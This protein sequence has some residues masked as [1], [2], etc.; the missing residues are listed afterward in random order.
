[1]SNKTASAISVFR[2]QFWVSTLAIMI[3]IWSKSVLW[4]KSRKTV[5]SKWP[6]NRK[7]YS[8]KLSKS[9]HPYCHWGYLQW[10]LLGKEVIVYWPQMWG[11]VEK[12]IEVLQRDRWFGFAYVDI[13]V[14][15]ELWKKKYP[16]CFTTN[17]FHVVPCHCPSK[18][19]LTWSRCKPMHDQRKLVYTLLVFNPVVQMT[20]LNDYAAEMFYNWSSR[21][22]WTKS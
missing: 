11:N 10:V 16:C 18:D 5:I 9:H 17:P 7:M 4:P 8:V 19:S 12:L 3:W 20:M 1:M 22:S 2:Y 13:K 15:K 21:G 14:P 6:A